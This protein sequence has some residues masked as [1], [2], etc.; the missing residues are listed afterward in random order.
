[1]LM[2]K[3]LPV[4]VWLLCSVQS[5]ALYTP[6]SS[7]IVPWDAG[8][9]GGIPVAYT[10]SVNVKDA[11]YNAVGDGV[12]ND[13]AAIQ[14]AMGDCTAFG[15]VY[16]PAGTYMIDDDLIMGPGHG[17]GTSEPMMLKG[18]SKT[19][20]TIVI[21]A[22]STRPGIW[23]QGSSPTGIEN[24]LNSGY[25]KGSTSV[26]ANT[27]T[28][29]AAGDYVVVGQDNDSASV[30]GNLQSPGTDLQRQFNRIYSITGTTVYLERPLYY[31]Y[32]AVLSPYMEEFANMA[33]GYGLE[34]FTITA[35]VG[36]TSSH[37]I[38]YTRAVNS[39]AQN[40]RTTNF[41]SRGLS[42]Q[43]CFRSEVR[44][45]LADRSHILSTSKYGFQMYGGSTDCLFEDNL[46][47]QAS[48][49]FLIQ[50]GTM[51]SVIAYNFFYAGWG[52]NVVPTS[53]PD[54]N[55]SMVGA[56]TVHGDA[57]AWNLFEGNVAPWLLDSDNVWG[58]NPTNTHFRNLATR[59][60]P[61]FIEMGANYLPFGERGFRVEEDNYGHNVIN[62]I[63][64]DGTDDASNPSLYY[65][66]EGDLDSEVTN[67]MVFHGNY[68]SDTGTQ[69]DPAIADQTFPA[70]YY[71]ESKPDWFGNIDWPAIG[72]DVPDSYLDITP[73]NI[74]PA[75]ARFF[76]YEYLDPP[77]GLGLWW[78]TVDPA[79]TGMEM[80][81]DSLTD[82]SQ[83]S[84]C[85]GYWRMNGIGDEIDVSGEGNDL[86]EVSGTIPR[87]GDVPPLYTGWSRDFEKGDTERL[88]SGTISPSMAAISGA[89]TFTCWLKPESVQVG[90]QIFV[91]LYETSSEPSK[92][93]TSQ[94]SPSMSL[95]FSYNTTSSGPYVQSTFGFVLAPVGEWTHIG[96][97]YEPQADP[98]KDFKLYLNGQLTQM[99]STPVTEIYADPSSI[100]TLGNRS[101]APSTSFDGMMDDAALFDEAFT[102]ENIYFI[103]KNGVDGKNGSAD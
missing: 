15:Y 33:D 89:M 27:I 67:S 93:F 50:G 30:F 40:V 2:I 37:N 97:V 47:A 95:R 60:E 65:V 4:V 44:L 68:R 96:I 3:Y 77:P 57:A 20:T 23:I 24:A 84:S 64:M 85:V 35:E 13:T 100:F 81:S 8:I 101:D 73:T 103:Y 39:W 9:P 62:N 72:S 10:Q 80:K 53:A 29:L 11:P 41:V 90:N 1:M 7:R 45:S 42:F 46:A 49:G 12:A 69:Y 18:E 26:V 19:N 22:S 16:M 55:Q 86:S 79:V 63:S 34:D 76:G 43:T 75:V 31:D 52:T 92:A 78:E 61:P 56:I 5:F 98:G 82:F 99:G 66:F 94:L 32:S 70:S 59:S 51:G 38:L 83:L 54:Q 71:L 17:N 74:I 87:V 58:S 48:A 91:G 102:P 6:D 21:D 25:T 88:V 28:G 14:S 36:T